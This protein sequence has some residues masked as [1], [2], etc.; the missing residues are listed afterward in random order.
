MQSLEDI[1]GPK[2][3]PDV[4]EFELVRQKYSYKKFARRLKPL[5]IP[6]EHKDDV[7]QPPSEYPNFDSED[8]MQDLEPWY[9]TKVRSKGRTPIARTV[10][11]E[12]DTKLV[13][14][15]HNLL[16]GILVPLQLPLPRKINRSRIIKRA[17]DE[18]KFKM[19][20]FDSVV[21]NGIRTFKRVNG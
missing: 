3:R 13:E 7:K 9:L 12:I 2:H 20:Q 21:S 15:R 16:N 18:N 19:Q 8:P 4:S 11:P 6:V 14:L 5:T 17:T 10:H 1:L